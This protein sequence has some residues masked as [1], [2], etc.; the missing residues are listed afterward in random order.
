MN[1][2]VYREI[3]PLVARRK[4]REERRRTLKIKLMLR[5]VELRKILH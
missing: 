5:L 1:E 4:R 3:S 2:I